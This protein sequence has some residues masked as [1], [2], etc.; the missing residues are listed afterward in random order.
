MKKFEVWINNRSAFLLKEI[1][2]YHPDS[3]NY[4]TFWREQKKRCIEG[5]WAQDTKDPED[6]GSWRYMPPQLYFYAN[7]G[8][9]LHKPVGAPR[10]APRQ[11][12]RPNLD[13][14]DWEFFYAW[15]IARGFS[16]FDGDEEFT[17]CRDVN[18]YEQ[19]GLDYDIPSSA[20]TKDGKIKSY[21]DAKEYLLKTH[22]KMLGKPLYD[23][24]ALN[25]MV[26]GTR[27]GGKSYWMSQ[28]CALHEVLFDGLKYYDPT[29]KTVST[30]EICVGSAIAAKSSEMLQKTQMGMDNLPG[31]WKKG[32]SE[33]VPAPFYRKMSGT[34][35]PNNVKNP[36]K[37][38]YEKKINGEWKKVGSGSNIKHVVY[39]IENP[40]AAAGGRYSVSIVEEVG[41]TNN[42][43]VIHGSN[44][45]TMRIE[46]KF[47]SGLYGGTGG[48]IEKII[49]SE[50]IFRDPDGYDMVSFDDTWENSGKIGLFI[51]A[52]RGDRK[53]KDENGN[54]KEVEALREYEARREKKRKAKSSSALE[55]EQMNYPLKPSEI[56]LNKAVNK[57]SVKDARA[58]LSELVSGNTPD[59]SYKGHFTLTD[60]G[61]SWVT[62]TDTP[63]RDF[64]I[65]NSNTNL[66]G[67]VEIFAMP[68][69]KEDDSVQAGRYL[70]A[71]LLPGE[72]VLTTNGIKNVED[73]VQEDMLY[74]ELGKEVNIKR[75]INLDVIDEDVYTVKMANTLRTTTFTSEHPILSSIP[76]NGYVSY[77]KSKRLGINQRFKKF[78]FEYKPVSELTDKDWVKVP[79]LY[80]TVNDFDV[81][82]LWINADNRIDRLVDSPLDKEDFWW[83]IGLFIGDG[84]VDSNGYRISVSFNS[85]ETQYI[86]KFKRVVKELFNRSVSSRIKNGSTTCSFRFTQLAIFLNLH[87]RKYA[88]GKTLPEWVKK[89]DNNFKLNIIL[90]YINSDGCVYV[91]DNNFS[92]EFISINLSLLESVQDILFSLGIISSITLLRGE[93]EHQ[94]GDKLSKTQKTYH[95]RLA[96]RESLVLAKAINSL[97]D[98]KLSKLNNYINTIDSIQKQTF[99]C[100]FSD[101]LKYIYFKVDSIVKST[102]TG[103]VYN[104]ECETNTFMCHH[105]TTHNCDPIDDDDNQDVTRSLQ[106]FWV[107]D[108]WTD[109]LVLEYTARTRFTKE[110][111]EQCRRALLFYNA[112][113][114]YENQK[115]GIYQYFETVNATYMLADTPKYLKDMALQKIN[116]VG[117]RAKGVYMSEGLKPY[118]L[119][120]FVA[121]TDSKLPN[122]E[123]TRMYSIKSQAL[124]K[125]IIF[126][127]KGK[128]S[129]RLSSLIVLMIYRESLVK[130]IESAKE[131]VVSQSDDP[132]FDRLYGKKFGKAM[133]NRTGL[134]R[135]GLSKDNPNTTFA[136]LLNS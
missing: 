36:W 67:C 61:V 42:L 66:E 46:H 86:D 77:A 84:W 32:T 26:L 68:V 25:L 108:L 10:T 51:P 20:Y 104:F 122:S 117:N 83:F 98:L 62:T 4:I 90:G 57:F 2:Q 113:L 123:K 131:V 22:Y 81:N 23:N 38:E 99:G 101:D 28:G 49:E 128:N 7:F 52:H 87:I 136:E 79:N 58:V 120:L 45:A 3:S 75:F 44:D 15:L 92:I 19:D 116:T 85:K 9:I 13:D 111:Y 12:V 47:G 16:G 59:N 109:D 65:T 40:E 124:L 69:K 53:Y 74:N 130:Y 121:W 41:L 127:H 88:L 114:L 21:I 76:K 82:S 37:F 24:T 93:K 34:L 11:K 134:D 1:P 80:R 100:F 133:F 73:V 39:T 110:F 115:K 102:Y 105:I 54:T 72:G 135:S 63:I 106:S 48:N 30:A 29:N 50:I 112:T 103:K 89:L 8:T 70:A 95:L 94:F 125:E 17:C 14:I 31:V 64:P 97:E 55:L 33:E 35:S 96:N 56:F 91:R 119:E 78:N 107:L 43:L 60:T 6:K 118:A 129:D 18:V 126:H 71:C 5:F 27:G 132:F